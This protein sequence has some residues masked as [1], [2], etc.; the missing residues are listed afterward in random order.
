MADPPWQYALFLLLS[1]ILTFI[2]TGTSL[3]TYLDDISLADGAF[4]NRN[5]FEQFREDDID[6]AV[7]KASSQRHVP[8]AEVPELLPMTRSIILKRDVTPD[9]P[10]YDHEV[11]NLADAT[12]AKL[13]NFHTCL[14]KQMG[15]QE[16]SR[17]KLHAANQLCLFEAFTDLEVLLDARGVNEV[18]YGGLGLGDDIWEEEG[19]HYVRAGRAQGGGWFLVR[20][21]E[22][23]DVVNQESWAHYV[24]NQP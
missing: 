12:S 20:N 22:K 18:G 5:I 14:H 9:F 24:P 11:A 4:K 2:L 21:G 6:A 23:Q 7:F 8:T 16:T 10:F 13:K 3:R 1:I 17:R 19:A 15:Y